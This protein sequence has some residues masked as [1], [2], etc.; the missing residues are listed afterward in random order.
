MQRLLANLWRILLMLV[1]TY[2]LIDVIK[3][4]SATIIII[5][6]LSGYFIVI[7]PIGKFF[8][9]YS[10]SKNHEQPKTWVGRS[11]YTIGLYCYALT[12]WMGRN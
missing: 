3:N 5:G 8:I 4:G 10:E 11:L 1:Y 6:I 12:Q 9:E 7:Y 2:K